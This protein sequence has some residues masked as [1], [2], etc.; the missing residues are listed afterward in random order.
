MEKIRKARQRVWKIIA[1]ASVAL[2]AISLVMLAVAW[3]VPETEAG[4]IAEKMLA[5]RVLPQWITGSDFA[6]PG[7]TGHF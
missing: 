1:V 3:V 6:L 7:G 5:V 2:F 4:R